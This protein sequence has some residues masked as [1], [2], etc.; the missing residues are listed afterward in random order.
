MHPRSSAPAYAL[1]ER[2]LGAV[3][4]HLLSGG[5]HNGVDEPFQRLRRQ[6]GDQIC[7]GICHVVKVETAE[8]DLK[9]L[10]VTRPRSRPSHA[11]RVRHGR[12]CDSSS[13]HCCVQCVRASSTALA[14]LRASPTSRT[15][16]YRT[17]RSHAWIG[18]TS[19]RAT[20]ARCLRARAVLFVDH[21]HRRNHLCRRRRYHLGRRHHRHPRPQPRV[22]IGVPTMKPLTLGNAHTLSSARAAPFAAHGPC[23]HQSS[24]R[25]LVLIG[26][27]CRVI[28]TNAIT[29]L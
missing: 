7:S 17:W 13:V 9:P 19:I 23:L 6:R 24:C 18:A 21:R 28:S 16:Y 8:T 4:P 29:S 2:Q 15:T 14:H 27:A 12:L 5:R 22:R 26:S 20:P 25:Q 1:L 3:L 10:D 11:R